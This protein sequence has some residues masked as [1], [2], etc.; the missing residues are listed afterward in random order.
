MMRR[1]V[2]V[3]ALIGVFLSTALVPPSVHLVRNVTVMGRSVP[4]ATDLRVDVREF[5]YLH[6][7]DDDDFEFR[8]WNYTYE[9]MGANVSLYNVTSGELY[10]S[11]LTDGTG[12]AVFYNLP[13]GTYKWNVT[14]NGAP[15]TVKEGQIVSNGPEATVDMQL[16]NLDLQN[17]DDDL[18]ANVYDVGGDPGQGLNF[19]VYLDNGTIYSTL[20]LGSD[21]VANVTDIPIGNYTWN[22]T[23][24][25][26][27]YA[28]ELLASQAFESNGTAMYVHQTIA[29]FVGD[30]D[31]YDL[32][33]FVYYE[34]SIDPVAGALVNVT[35]KNGTVIDAKYTPLNG[36]VLFE[37]LPAAFINWTVTF[38]GQ[39]VD[40]GEYH[41]NLT[42]VSTDV[43]DP[44]IVSPGDVSYLYGTHNVTVSWQVY[45]E[46]PKELRVYVDDD[47]SLTE[48]WVNSTYTLV[49]NV[50]GYDLGVYDLRFEAED[51]NGNIATDT[52]TLRVY[53]NVSPVIEGPP[54]VTF[55]FAESGHTLTWNIT[56][57]H[58]DVYVVTRNGTETANGTINPDYP[59][60][61][62]S[63][64]GLRAGVYEYVLTVN[65]TSG[66]TASDSVTVTVKTDDV[67]PVIVFSPSEIYYNRG[68]E[69]VLYN[70]TARDE[71]KANY[72]IEVDGFVVV[73]QDWT[74]ENI[75]FDFSGLAEGEH[76]V[77]L[78]VYD[79]GGNSATSA[80]HVVVG[81]PTVLMFGVVLT[82]VI[83]AAF[84]VVGVRY[85]LKTR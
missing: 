69:N 41:Y 65:D 58:P 79:I 30:A 45:D 20:V 26:G 40:K 29:P 47:L 85:Y 44:V 27:P 13:Q 55:Y 50:T 21:G 73:Q 33:V 35:Y 34:M 15:G 75:W 25:S 54:D 11:K 10:D 78:T 37:D 63:L 32:E 72:T 12:Y 80:V 14:W 23:V 16:G 67:P 76:W 1:S 22:V 19:T 74:D 2:F 38:G 46:H 17:D 71:F 57:E 53:E 9:V 83:I 70:W 39:P 64:S 59:V 3:V 60:V 42:T 52:I 43:R 51:Q 49:F 4:A 84:V 5:N 7:Y 28:G 61:T 36:T 48:Q 82:G 8:V 66:N 24:V 31:Y 18:L 77:V 81:P 6:A 68:D 56:E 62:V